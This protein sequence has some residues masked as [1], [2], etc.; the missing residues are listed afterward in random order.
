[1]SQPTPPAAG[2]ECFE[3]GVVDAAWAS[4]SL[5]LHL[6]IAC[7][8]IH[9]GLGVHTSRVKSKTLDLLTERETRMLDV[10]AHRRLQHHLAEHGVEYTAWRQLPLSQRYSTHELELYRR[11]LAEGEAPFDPPPRE[12]TTAPS[13]L[14]GDPPET[15]GPSPEAAWPLDEVVW[16]PDA[17]APRCELCR[18]VFDL[19]ERRHHCRAC[20]RCVCG[21]CSPRACRAPATNARRCK[22]CAPPPARLI[23][24]LAFS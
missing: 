18:V 19:F 12:A 14:A 17:A 5:G 11:R 3:C 1:M 21:S 2:N 24:G 13:E 6:C 9:R 23:P 4:I 10:D 16:T 8:G 22:L 20:G 7:A 15:V